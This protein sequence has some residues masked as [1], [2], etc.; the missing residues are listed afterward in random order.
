MNTTTGIS[1]CQKKLSASRDLPGEYVP[2]CTS[3]GEYEK[4]QCHSSTGHCW[5]VDKQTGREIG[6]TRKPAGNKVD[7]STCVKPCHST[8]KEVC[9]SNG[10]TYPNEC[11]F[12]NAKCKDQSLTIVSFFACKK[13]DD[14]DPFPPPLFTVYGKL[15]F[16]PSLPSI[17]DRSCVTVKAQEAIYCDYV[18]GVANNG[19]DR[20]LNERQYKTVLLGDDGTFKFK[21]SF[22]SDRPVPVLLSATLNM[23]WCRD[24]NKKKSDWIRDGDYFTDY[25][26][27][28]ELNDR[29]LEYRK[30]VTMKLFKM[31]QQDQPSP[32]GICLKSCLKLFNFFYPSLLT[33]ISSV[34]LN[35]NDNMVN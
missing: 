1:D 15:L 32:Q 33:Y 20:T 17:P 22:G 26:I 8:R 12:E 16:P 14:N 23:G 11:E 30:D 2:Q 24:L 7:C 31:T 19:C 35:L 25:E 29:E 5:C 3:N 13:N 10:E 18:P 9:G 34:L 6:G 4:M 27:N 28:V 21:V